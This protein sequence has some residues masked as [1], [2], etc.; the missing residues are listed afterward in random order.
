MVV[1]IGAD[2]SDLTSGLRQGEVAVKNTERAINTSAQSATRS[3]QGFNKL[4]G[5]LTSLAVASGALPG[6]LG[7]LASTLSGFALG[8]AVTAGVL[9]GLA[10]MGFAWKKLTEDVRTAEEAN[11]RATKAVMADALKLTG[12]N[13]AQLK[14][15]L[16][17]LEQQKNAIAEAIRLQ[18]TPTSAMPDLN[19]PEGRLR[20]GMAD[21]ATKATFTHPTVSGEDQ[22]RF[23]QLEERIREVS[24]ALKD[25][26]EASRKL[27]DSVR[28]SF[29]QDVANAVMKA[30]NEVDAFMRALHANLINEPGA[31]QFFRSRPVGPD[32]P[33]LGDKMAKMAADATEKELRVSTQLHVSVESINA[34]LKERIRLLREAG[35]LSKDEMDTATK[36]REV[37]KGV[38]LGAVGG[39]A[40]KMGLGGTASGVIGAVAMGSGPLGIAAAGISGLVGDL[41]NMGNA[42]KQARE[43]MRQFTLHMQEFIL[44]AQ[45]ELGIVSGPDA[46][47]RRTR[48]QI[49]EQ[50]RAILDQAGITDAKF[51]NDPL[52]RSQRNPESFD[53]LRQQYEE[54]DALQERLIDKRREEASA[55]DR[56]NKGLREFAS[57]LSNIPRVL[58]VNL[59]RHL[60]TNQPAPN[61][62][63]PAPD[64]MNPT[65]PTTKRPRNKNDPA[66]SGNVY[67]F[68]ITA[69]DAQDAANRVGRVVDRTKSRGGKSRLATA[70]T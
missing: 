41:L 47:E 10:A 4:R 11:A 38:A 61:P 42:A 19:T 33:G 28:D 12:F 35:V 30:R 51:F 26:Q 16:A 32:V 39:V 13:E 55:L 20:F 22:A 62:D 44:S 3:A 7:R 50:K 68:F 1:R 5:N 8:G 14:I 23:V 56:A 6:P 34:S 29:E 64:P 37:L 24:A 53:R 48:T 45:V 43:Q 46:A 63:M 15:K 67:N 66:D 2:L 58:N 27:T 70:V 59:L 65:V 36:T 54:L 49:D 18:G 31:E 25:A 60:V 69:N 9:A 21:A 40:S 17:T 52:I 57:A